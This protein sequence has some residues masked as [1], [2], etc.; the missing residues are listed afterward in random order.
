MSKSKDKG[1]IIVSPNDSGMNW[2]ACTGPGCPYSC[3]RCEWN[4]CKNCC[5][6]LHGVAIQMATHRGHT[7]MFGFKPNN[8][9]ATVETEKVESKPTP[10]FG[11]IEK[12]T[13]PDYPLEM[14]KTW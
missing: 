2:G 7:K 5:E 1:P 4:C 11:E 13:E 6:K 8:S 3:Y 14:S 10:K 9:N 12:V